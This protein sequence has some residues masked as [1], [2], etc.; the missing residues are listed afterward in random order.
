[1][2]FTKKMMIALSTALVFATAFGSAADAQSR[3][4]R[5]QAGQVDYGA[6]NKG[7][8]TNGD[9][10]FLSAVQSSQVC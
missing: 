7:C 4:S 5:Q 10:S 2:M 1:M 8:I 6:T 9:D 3:S